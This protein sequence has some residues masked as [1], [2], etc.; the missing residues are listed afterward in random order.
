MSPELNTAFWKW[1]SGSKV[2]DENGN[3]L[4]VYRGQRK[5][6]RPTSFAT[7]FGR[8]T[9]A[10][11]PVHEIASVYA[12]TQDFWGGGSAEY[13]TGANVGAYFLSI[14]NPAD[15]REFGV[16]DSLGHI[17][18][19]LFE[20]DFNNE[21]TEG[22]TLGLN[23]FLMIAEGLKARSEQSVFK[24]ESDA[25]QGWGEAEPEDVVNDLYAC[26]AEDVDPVDTF[27]HYFDAITTDVYALADSKNFTNLL[28][29]AGYD[30]IIHK[31]VGEI[32]VKFIDQPPEQ[33]PGIDVDDDYSF[34]TYRPFYQ[35]QIKSATGNRGTWDPQDR[36]VS[37]N[38]QM[39]DS[40]ATSRP[41]VT[42]LHRKI[43]N[44]LGP[45]NLDLG[46]GKYDISTEF[47]AQHGVKN[48]VLDP[49]N[50]SEAHN[51]DVLRY[52]EDNGGADSVTVCNVLNVINDA[53]TRADVIQM[54]KTWAKGPVYFSTYEGSGP[55]TG[56]G[57]GS[58]T[59]D[60]WQEN[61]K[62]RTYIP[63]IAPY[64]NTVKMLPG[65]GSKIIVAFDA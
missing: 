27:Q 28:K 56:S 18:M 60:G 49:Y 46:G 43:A 52:L 41:Q 11:T 26:Q 24:F 36:D 12:R 23:D 45:V 32:A 1:F 48:L 64:F 4:V 25:Y 62:T 5:T 51:A 50:R 21:E 37:H 53:Q 63:E 8:A 44:L 47:L 42:A 31:D 29:R 7:T 6:P 34:D 65:S 58:K 38:P 19:S 17:L 30:G 35:T 13:E 59:R 40:A 54:A 61:R 20:I 15:L 2:V 14:K 55:E 39:I 10:F 9:P 16:H 57:I 3:P 33:I 22:K